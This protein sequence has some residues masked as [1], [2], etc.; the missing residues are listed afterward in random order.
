MKLTILGSGTSVPHP[1]RAAPSHWI[2][3]SK[4]SLLLD[5][6]ADAAH[7]MAQERLD[8]PNL[9]CIWISHFHLDHMGGLVAF[10]FGAKWAP[11]IQ[12]RTKPLRIFG[13][14]GLRRIF[15]AMNASNN[16]KLLEQAFPVEFVEVG[17]GKDFEI[18]PGLATT[19]FSTP[20]T[21]ESLALRLKDEDS[22]LFIYTS[23]TG[24]SEDL[25]PFAKDADLLL[26]E[27]SFTRNKP[28]Q[29][30]LELVDAMRIAREC[31]PKKLVL[32]HLYP[33][34]DGVDLV[35]EARPLWSG[36]TIEAN[37]GLRLEI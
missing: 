20:H 6:S 14:N 3:T 15:E 34:W 9:D 2:E 30:H 25:I 21:E 24:F 17:P 37:D 35:A 10:L 23:D 31:A 16:Y 26:M 19:T 29:K 7:R 36:E 12:S 4:G 5:I 11:P 33:E 13:P 1:Q 27:C 28:I 32:T 8:W 18:L 22:K